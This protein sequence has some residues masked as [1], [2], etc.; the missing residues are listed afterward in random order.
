MRC[1]SE[2]SD[3]TLPVLFGPSDATLRPARSW[4]G[5][6]APPGAVCASGAL[7]AIAVVTDRSPMTLAAFRSIISAYQDLLLNSVFTR[8]QKLI[9]R[10]ACRGD[11]GSVPSLLTCFSMRMGSPV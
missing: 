6:A 4:P 2:F 1:R 3:W 10:D 8:A 7:C 9:D 11:T 5:A